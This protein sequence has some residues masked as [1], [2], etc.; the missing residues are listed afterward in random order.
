MIIRNMR[1]A[2]DARP[3][4]QDGFG[5]AR[6]TSELIDALAALDKTNDYCLIVNSDKLASR[7]TGWRNFSLWRIGAGWMSL[8]EQAELPFVLGQIR[9]DVFHATSFVV[10]LYKTCPTVVTIHDL[11]HLV[12]PKNYG[13]KQGLYFRAL[14]HALL[15][16]SLIIA[17]SAATKN[18]LI[19][20]YKLRSEKVKV[21]PLAVNKSFRPLGVAEVNEYRK[22]KGLPGKFVLF[23]GSRKKH[24]NLRLLL[25]AWAKLNQAGEIKIPLVITGKPDELT[26]EYSQS[27]KIIFLGAVQGQELPK[28]YNAASLFV[29]P[30][31]Y[32][33]FGL[34]PLEAMACGTPVITTDVSSLPE[35]VG[36]AGLLVPPGDVTS[37][38][39]A[40]TK[41]LTDNDQAIKMR[42]AGLK[43][44]AGFSW[45]KCARET[46]A[47]YQAASAK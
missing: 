13:L 27:G 39:R 2:I 22:G 5:I 17:D 20:F 23:V 25:D 31:L 24:K 47:A 40:M 14:K 29:F 36:E 19:M 4:E 45:D 41:V 43:R 7:I 6:Y 16:A 38:A 33:G 3:A 18:D 32:E 10:P 34:P 44:A 1:I 12:F 37:L 8:R 46:L 28:L 30:S 35:V 15:R 9:P 42:V 11:I 21:I 26:Q